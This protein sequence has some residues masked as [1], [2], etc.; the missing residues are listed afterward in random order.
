VTKNRQPKVRT[1]IPPRGSMS[2]H[3]LQNDT[4]TTQ[5]R[6][7]G[8]T[9]IVPGPSRLY[10]S[11]SSRKVTTGSS[12]D[13]FAIILLP[14]DDDIEFWCRQRALANRRRVHN[15][16]RIEEESTRQ[17]DTPLLDRLVGDL[18]AIRLAEQH[19]GRYWLCKECNVIALADGPYRRAALTEAGWDPIKQMC[20]D[21]QA[22]KVEIEVSPN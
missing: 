4:M 1:R 16:R 8:G 9:P 10:R 13:T 15:R 22:P 19:P 21:C 20:P 2:G 3:K 5:G 18:R 12:A 7:A 17:R 14:V 6:A 11:S